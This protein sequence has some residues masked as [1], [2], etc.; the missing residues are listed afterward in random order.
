MINFPSIKL[1]IFRKLEYFL[2]LKKLNEQFDA[3][4]EILLTSKNDKEEYLGNFPTW[5][6]EKK[7]LFWTYVFHKHLG[8][9]ISI[10][11]FLNKEEWYRKEVL[12]H[13]SGYEPKI[14]EYKNKSEEEIQNELKQAFK[15]Y[16]DNHMLNIVVEPEKIQNKNDKLKD[17]FL[18]QNE[19]INAGIE[20]TL[21]NLVQRGFAEEKK[22]GEFI[23]SKEGLSFGE[24][25]WYLYMPKVNKKYSK[26]FGVCPRNVNRK[27]EKYLFKLNTNYF[28]FWIMNLQLWS[29]YG[30]TLIAGLFATLEVLDGVNLLDNLQVIS[31]KYFNK[32][33]VIIILCIPFTLFISSFIVN[34]VYNAWLKNRKYTNVLMLLKN[35]K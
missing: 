22:K 9:P 34:I 14:T 32:Y 17:I 2:I 19:I 21:K 10:N 29:F 20:G 30:F 6:C 31:K 12:K 13:Y 25:L 35:E 4:F 24:L 26:V 8:S 15:D 27:N 5:E 3:Q 7:I 1:N 16:F 11:D 18:S 33:F 23:V 28:S